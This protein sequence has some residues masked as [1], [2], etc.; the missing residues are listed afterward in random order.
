MKLSGDRCSSSGRFQCNCAVFCETDLIV[1][2]ILLLAVCAQGA[3]R[4]VLLEG[5]TQWNCGPCA[6]W[7]PQ[8]RTVMHGDDGRDTVMA[9]KYHVSWPAPNNDAFYL[10]NTDRSR[11]AHQ[12]LRR[13]GRARWLARRR[14]DGQHRQR[15]GG[16]EESDPR[17]LQSAGAVRDRDVGVSGGHHRHC[18][19]AARSRRN[20]ICP[21]RGCAWC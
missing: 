1:V 3:V 20:A 7:N 21:P 17:P 13:D 18:R 11:G 19:S 5:F 6:G 8:E 4:T 15:R 12:L 2:A 10:Y 16:A 14:G 9:I